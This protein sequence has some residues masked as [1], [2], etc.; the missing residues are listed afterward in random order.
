M[1]LDAGSDAARFASWESRA[2]D[3]IDHNI[4][5]FRGET[6]VQPSPSYEG[7]WARDTMI[8]ALGLLD[9]G[10]S[11]LAGRLLRTWATYQIRPEDDPADYVLLNK[12]R[13][14]WTESE[15][16][17]PDVAWLQAN[18]GGLATSVYVGRDTFPDGTREIYSCH[19]DPDSTMWWLVACGRYADLSG[20]A[21]VTRDLRPQLQAAVDNLVRRD[22]DGDLLIEQC[23]NEDW[24]DH[25]RRH[26]KVTYTQAVWFAAVRAA[27]ALGLHGPDPDPVRAAIRRTLLRTSGPLDWSCPRTRSSRLAQD[28]SLLIV[29]GVLDGEEAGWLLQQLDRL[30]APHGHRVVTPAFRSSRMGPYHFKR[31]EYQNAGIWTWLTGWE[32]QARALSGEVDSARSL[33]ASCFCPGCDRI[34][35]WVEPLR[36]GRHNPNFATGAGSI[37]S[38][39]ARLREAER[40]RDT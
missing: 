29:H 10:N 36:G 4:G 31:G 15:I 13:L 20:D 37:L 14:A 25:M 7:L 40:V 5:I 33:I 22:S 30:G 17:H 1:V 18:R 28:F 32:A 39:M 6:I 8:V 35:E 12:H 11:S 16:S 3:T 34:Y 9:A 23:P 26:G 27:A 21:H 24:A 2:L 19:P 38:A